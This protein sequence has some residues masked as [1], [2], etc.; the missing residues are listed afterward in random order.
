MRH[1]ATAL[2]FQGDNLQ[3]AAGA[4]LESPGNLVELFL[5]DRNSLYITLESRSSSPFEHSRQEKTR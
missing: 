3:E 1:T 5:R 2:V 4:H